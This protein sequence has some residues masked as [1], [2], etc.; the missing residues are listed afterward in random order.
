MPCLV[1]L[2]NMSL[3]RVNRH[4]CGPEIYSEDHDSSIFRQSSNPVCGFS[5]MEQVR[6]C[7]VWPMENWLGSSMNHIQGWRTVWIWYCHGPQN[8]SL[9]WTLCCFFTRA[10]VYCT[11]CCWVLSSIIA[12]Y[13]YYYYYCLSFTRGTYERRYRCHPDHHTHQK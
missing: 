12:Y 5:M 2:H 3:V 4:V 7:A 13:H 10:V 1:R 8:R 6:L 9:V 11:L